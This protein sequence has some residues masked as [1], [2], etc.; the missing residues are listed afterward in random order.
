[1]DPDNQ[2]L[3]WPP[4]MGTV[5]QCFNSLSGISTIPSPVTVKHHMLVAPSDS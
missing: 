2:L 1:M 4:V 5:L 3:M